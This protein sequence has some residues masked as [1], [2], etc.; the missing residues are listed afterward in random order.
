MTTWRDEIT[1]ARERHERNTLP[2]LSGERGNRWTH[3][4]AKSCGQ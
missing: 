2:E 4:L 1:A 3:S